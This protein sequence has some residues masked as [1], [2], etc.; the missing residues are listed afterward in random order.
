[1]DAH[2][3]RRGQ[4]QVTRHLRVAARPGTQARVRRVPEEA[5]RRDPEEEP[6]AAAMTA[7]ARVI[8]FVLLMI[9]GTTTAQQD[10]TFDGKAARVIENDKLAMTLLSNGGAM[11]KLVRKD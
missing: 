11:V 5:P 3:I 4:V 10:I 1:M 7:A 6:E 8:A 9:A 2:E